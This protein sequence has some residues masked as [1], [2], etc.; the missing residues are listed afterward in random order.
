MVS[1]LEVLRII[2]DHRIVGMV[3][4]PLEEVLFATFIGVLCGSDDWDEI[5][6]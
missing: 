2:P 3:T 6:I 5:D 1:F 4:Y